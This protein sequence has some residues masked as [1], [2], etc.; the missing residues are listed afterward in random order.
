MDDIRQ[1]DDGDFY[2]AVLPQLQM[3]EK[4]R[5]AKRKVF[6]WRKKAGIAIG[7]VLIPA[8]GYLDFLLL[9]MQ[10]GDDSGAGFTAL[11]AGGLYWWITQPKRQ[12]AAAYKTDIL[13]K[14]ARLFGNLTYVPKGKIDMAVIKPSK[15]VPAH[16]QYRTDDYFTGIYR[17]VDLAFA[18]IELKQ[19]QQ[20]GKRTTYVTVFKGLA[21][22]LTMPKNKFFGHTALVGNSAGVFQWFKKKSLGLQRADLVDPAFEKQF[23]VYTN[24]QVEA[25][26]LIH[27]VMIE[28]IKN[29][30]NTYGADG[31][32]AAYWEKHLLVMMKSNKDHFE[33]A[34]I[35]VPATAPENLTT[36]KREV[37]EVLNLI[38][39][40]EQY[41]AEAAHKVA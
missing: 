34:G 9:R 26:Y 33:P 17:G 27:P 11:V 25:R 37:S 23:D 29:M 8:A 19:R 16:H 32:M 21:I 1:I 5:L 38:D 30:R 6:L 40:M 10:S 22:L 24:D 4:L 3:L 12:Y 18:E 7:S 31:I 13:P 14:I 35:D 36:M 28:K 15:I 39:Q 2:Q 20:S 41:D